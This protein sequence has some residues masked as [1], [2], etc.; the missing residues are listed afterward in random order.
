MSFFF[1]FLFF[2]G[3][4][5]GADPPDKVAPAPKGVEYFTPRINGP[6]PEI[7]ERARQESSY[8]STAGPRSP[9]P[10]PRTVQ[11]HDAPRPPPPPRPLSGAISPRARNGHRRSSSSPTTQALRRHADRMLNKL[12]LE[13]FHSG[14][15]FNHQEALDFLVRNSSGA[16]CPSSPAAHAIV[17]TL[18]TSFPAL[19][20]AGSY[21]SLQGVSAEEYLAHLRSAGKGLGPVLSAFEISFAAL[22]RAEHSAA[23]LLLTCGFL[24]HSHIPHVLLLRASPV[25]DSPTLEGLLATLTSYRLVRP[26]TFNRSFSVDAAIHAH[27]RKLAAPDE[28]LRCLRMLRTAVSSEGKMFGNR[29]LPH[30]KACQRHLKRFEHQADSGDELREG[31]TWLA[32]VVEGAG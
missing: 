22:Q 3:G 2:S 7:G 11:R 25:Q 19:E 31:L 30:V 27:L 29:I 1:S 4:D 26:D 5:W 16:L 15:A 17:S 21:I 12:E 32:T 8:P 9:T 20:L 24:H 6:E 14:Y 28:G 23:D 13:D 10:V 18:L